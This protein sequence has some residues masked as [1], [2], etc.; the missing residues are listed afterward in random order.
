MVGALAVALHGEGG[1]EVIR[2]ARAPEVQHA[3]E[4]GRRLGVS[5]L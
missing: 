3:R 2:R 5:L 1:V 4:I